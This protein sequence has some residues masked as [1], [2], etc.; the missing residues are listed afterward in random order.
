MLKVERLSFS[1]PHKKLFENLSFLLEP[2]RVLHLKGSNGCGKST[3]LSILAGLRKP[4]SGELNFTDTSTNPV[5]LKHAIEYLAAEKGGLFL[6]MTARQNLAYWS[7]LKGYAIDVNGADQCLKEWGLGSA[8]ARHF[9]TQRFSTGMKR[10]LALARISMSRSPCLLLDEPLN[11]LDE[12]GVELFKSMVR[13]HK[14]RNGMAVIVSHE[15][16]ALR[17]LFTD[18]LT[19]G[20]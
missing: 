17:E 3:L 10:R 8:M 12:E 6:K 19:L 7:S 2:G 9:P 16:H 14:E 15:S 11:G 1:F 4:S 5:D 13:R 20:L 18:Q